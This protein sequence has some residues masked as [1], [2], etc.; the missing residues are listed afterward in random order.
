[1]VTRS[2]TIGSEPSRSRVRVVVTVFETHCVGMH[3]GVGVVTVR[4]L[5]HDVIVL[6]LVVGMVVDLLTMGVG[7]V[8][9]CG[10]VVLWVHFLSFLV[11]WPCFHS[12]SVETS[13]NQRRPLP[14]WVT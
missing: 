1:M 11:L 9:R 7:M 8:V 2:L 5:V 10:V 14:S 6:M 3:M 4:M 13:D 12:G